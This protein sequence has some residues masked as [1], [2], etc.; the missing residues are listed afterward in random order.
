MS[1]HL[2]TLLI[3]LRRSLDNGWNLLAVIC[4][5]FAPTALFLKHAAAFLIGKVNDLDPKIKNSAAF[6]YRALKRTVQNGPRETTLSSQ[7]LSAVKVSNIS[8]IFSPL[9]SHLLNLI[10][11]YVKS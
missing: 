6:C 1:L 9:H 4:S 11:F 8:C 3:T 5:S 7:E 2:S 10:S